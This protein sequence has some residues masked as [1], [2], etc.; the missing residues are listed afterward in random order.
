MKTFRI[1]VKGKVQGVFYRQSTKEKAI[2]LHLK[3]TVKNLSNGDVEV[4][5]TG[6]EENLHELCE[7]CKV[8]PPKAIV[9][10]I[11]IIHLDLTPFDNFSILR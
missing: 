3:G 1:I 4:I 8:G 5:A 11:T 10:G 2:A 9:A 7:W 6:A